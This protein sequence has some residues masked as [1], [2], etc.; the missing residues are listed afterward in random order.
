M[1]FD[2]RYFAGAPVPIRDCRTAIEDRARRRELCLMPSDSYGTT[3][4]TDSLGERPQPHRVSWKLGKDG[5]ERNGLAR[6]ASRKD[7]D[8]KRSARIGEKQTQYG[9]M[10]KYQG[11]EPEMSASETSRKKASRKRG[12]ILAR[13]SLRSKHLL[14]CKATWRGIGTVGTIFLRHCPVVPSTVIDPKGS[15]L[16]REAT[17]VASFFYW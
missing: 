6:R 13:S 4:R 17:Q 15:L 8:L 14:K 10:S 11:P 12:G 16:A 2:S 3:R 1:R 7:F 9:H 5:T